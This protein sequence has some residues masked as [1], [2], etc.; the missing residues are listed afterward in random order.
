MFP[1]GLE[2]WLNQRGCL[3]LRS[4][5]AMNQAATPN[6]ISKS[7]GSRLAEGDLYSEKIIRTY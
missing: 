6:K 5:A 2:E 1:A 4:P 3:A 7:I